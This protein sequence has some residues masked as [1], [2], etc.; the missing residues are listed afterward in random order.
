L[1]LLNCKLICLKYWIFRIL[2]DL[3]T[4]H[5]EILNILRWLDQN[6]LRLLHR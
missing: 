4:W 3:V 6:I 5:F 1:S 2:S